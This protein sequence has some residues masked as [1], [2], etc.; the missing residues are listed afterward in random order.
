MEVEEEETLREVQA[1]EL[2]LPTVT[3]GRLGL[4]VRRELKKIKIHNDGSSSQ[5]KDG[6]SIIKKKT[7]DIASNHVIEL[8]SRSCLFVCE[9]E[10]MESI[11]GGVQEVVGVLAEMGTRSKE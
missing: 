7:D 5:Q 4:G 1:I 3:E 11:T 9:R 6:S 8:N 10:I 2:I